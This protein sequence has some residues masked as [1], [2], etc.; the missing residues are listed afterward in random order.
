MEFIFKV[1]SGEKR[2][3]TFKAL[4]Q[5][6]KTT[7]KALTITFGEKLSLTCRIVELQDD[8]VKVN[9]MAF[10]RMEK[11]F[12]Q[13]PYHYFIPISSIVFVEEPRS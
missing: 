3:M 6:F 4:L 13:T 2:I 5:E 10:N 12:S 7:D 9:Q 1:L 8:F 11:T